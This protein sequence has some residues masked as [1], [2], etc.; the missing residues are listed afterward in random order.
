MRLNFVSNS[1]LSRLKYLWTVCA[2]FLFPTFLFGSLNLGGGLWFDEAG[3]FSEGL[4]VVVV[5]NKYGYIDT[6][7]RTVIRPKF[8]LPDPSLAK[9]D[10]ASVISFSGGLAL[11]ILNGKYGY[12][13][14]QGVIAISPQFDRAKAFADGLAWVSKNGK[15][16]YINQQGK[17]VIQLDS[18]EF[19]LNFARYVEKNLKKQEQSKLS[20]VPK[21]PSV[22]APSFSEGVAPLEHTDA[23]G[24]RIWGYINKSGNVV[25]EPVFNHALK[26]REG[27]AAIAPAAEAGKPTLWGFIDKSG[28]IAV[29]PRFNLVSHFSEGLAHCMMWDV[30]TDEFFTGDWTHVFINQKGTIVICPKFNGA[31]SFSEGLAWVKVGDK[32]GYIDKAGKLTIKPQFNGAGDFSEGLA[33][34]NVG[35]PA[36]AWA[37]L[38]GESIGKWGYINKTGKYV[39]EPKFHMA[40]DFS[41]GLAAI[42]LNG[43][44][45]FIDSKGRLLMRK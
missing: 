45:G 38:A 29:E 39:I 31:G 32:Y 44:W 43:K 23:D 5:D 21:F 20:E 36:P 18:L 2:V 37:E 25:I 41:D 16:G 3:S 8:E 15:P 22:F 33:K 17:M 28:N 24:Y 7:G 27:F 40:R 35:K 19:P 12:I 42:Q 26:F 10:G 1:M 6:T 4:A 34:V 14:K 13:N 30:D 11:A 9:W